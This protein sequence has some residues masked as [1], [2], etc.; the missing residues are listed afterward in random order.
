MILNLPA[1]QDVKSRLVSFLDK[2]NDRVSS[3][4]GQYEVKSRVSKFLGQRRKSPCDES[5]EDNLGHRNKRRKI[6]H[7]EEKDDQVEKKN[8]WQKSIEELE[9]KELPKRF[10]GVVQLMDRL[11]EKEVSLDDSFETVLFSKNTKRHAM[12][13]RSLRKLLKQQP[14]HPGLSWHKPGSDWV[15]TNKQELIKF[16]PVLLET[17]KEYQEA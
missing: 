12:T 2:Q 10:L 7:V 16:I 3:F 14:D 13:T 8:S 6:D 17:Y 1:V 9:N 15:P 11:L 5:T 4:L